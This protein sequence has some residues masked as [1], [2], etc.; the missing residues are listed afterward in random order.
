M[1]QGDAI[2]SVNICQEDSTRD[3]RECPEDVVLTTI[4]PT[5]GRTT[6]G[7]GEVTSAIVESADEIL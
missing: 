1:Q 6:V 7:Y 2:M 3:D 4:I 5:Q